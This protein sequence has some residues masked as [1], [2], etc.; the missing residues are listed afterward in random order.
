MTREYR[1]GARISTAPPPPRQREHRED[2]DGVSEWH[3]EPG[4]CYPGVPGASRIARAGLAW[5]GNGRLQNGY[6]R[7]SHLCI[8][9]G[10]PPQSASLA[11]PH[12]MMTSY[13]DELHLI[14]QH[15]SQL[16]CNFGLRKEY[17]FR[18]LLLCTL[19][20]ATL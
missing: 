2:G 10:Y 13:R 4:A 5:P 11:E 15:Q 6:T 1:H 12:S 17:G 19:Q 18:V 7:L 9:I 16:R 14:S 8:Q 3:A 20:T